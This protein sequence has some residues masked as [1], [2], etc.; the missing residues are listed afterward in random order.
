[1]VYAGMG[2]S[3][4]LFLPNLGIGK[5]TLASYFRLPMVPGF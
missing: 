5:H 2:M 1:M 3:Q 4:N